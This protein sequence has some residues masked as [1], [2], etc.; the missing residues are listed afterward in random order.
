[1][2]IELPSITTD[3]IGIIGMGTSSSASC[4]KCDTASDGMETFCE[5]VEGVILNE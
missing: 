1:M 3:I 2:H 4:D 5:I